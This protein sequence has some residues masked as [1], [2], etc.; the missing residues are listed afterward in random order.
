MDPVPFYPDPDPDSDPRLEKS[1]PDPGD[2]KIPD[3]TGSKSY[4]D[5]GFLIVQTKTFL[6]DYIA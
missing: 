3:P 1:D 4:L 5:I 6:K 2:P